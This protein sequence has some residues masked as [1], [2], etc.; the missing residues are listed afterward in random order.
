MDLTE[1]FAKQQQEIED[2]KKLRDAT[3]SNLKKEHE[4]L[5]AAFGG[6]ANMPEE[7]RKRIDGQVADFSKEWSMQGGTRHNDI[8]EQ[9]A[10]QREAITG[11]KSETPAQAKQQEKDMISEKQKDLQK[12]IAMQQAIRIKNEQKKRKR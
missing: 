3:W 4:T 10:K 7:Y 1:L 9:H 5:T 2:F 6:R 11:K 12:I 8:V